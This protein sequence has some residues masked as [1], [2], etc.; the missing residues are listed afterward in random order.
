MEPAAWAGRVV[1]GALD[2]GWTDLGSWTVLL[3][4][5]GV[6]ATGRVVQA[7]EPVEV[8]ADD[9]IVRRRAGR[10]V[11]DPG[12]ASGILDADGPSALLVGA[13][14]ARRKI[15]DLIMRVSAEEARS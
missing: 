11:L 15:A 12:P 4:A 7:G 5:L 14:F 3:S 6:D 8:T 9:L 2:V 10:L 1:M 13:A